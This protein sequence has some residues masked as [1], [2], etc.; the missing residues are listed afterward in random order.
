MYSAVPVCDMQS[1]ALCY[2]TIPCIAQAPQWS[3][4]TRDPG[5]QRVPLQCMLELSR[6][7]IFI[8]LCALVSALPSFANLIRY[9]G[10]CASAFSRANA[11]KT[12]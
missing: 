10:T 2:F 12:S 8:A 11:L 4:H 3:E 9:C 5:S 7:S 1:P 6:K